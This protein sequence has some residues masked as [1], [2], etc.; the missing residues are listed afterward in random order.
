MFVYYK[1]IDRMA[2]TEVLIKRVYDSVDENDGLRVLVD[3]LW[4]RGIS[5]DKLKCDIWA[6]EI[7]P[8]PELRKM[9]HADIENNWTAFTNG[10][11]QELELSPSFNDFIAKIRKD[12]PKRVTLLYA[13]KNEIKNH[14][15]ILQQEIIKKLGE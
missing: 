15:L 13:F 7:A 14:A 11:I 9:F 3:R 12:N 5:K 8:S 6:K 4:P 2:N 1:F 10:Y